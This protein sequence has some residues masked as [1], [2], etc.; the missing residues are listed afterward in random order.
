MSNQN[1]RK[2]NW[3]LY[4]FLWTSTFPSCIVLSY[5][6]RSGPQAKAW[7]WSFCGSA[8]QTNRI[9]QWQECLKSLQKSKH[10]SISFTL[11]A[12]FVWH[13]MAL[14]LKMITFAEAYKLFSIISSS[15]S[16]TLFL[17]FWTSLYLTNIWD[18]GVC[19]VFDHRDIQQKHWSD[20]VNTAD[21]NTQK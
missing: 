18:P 10:V 12:L 4:R 21:P 9:H 15:A 5:V 13:Q 8:A 17:K 16:Q 3:I 7:K 11:Q 6:K 14:K 19:D 1:D 2:E 20:H